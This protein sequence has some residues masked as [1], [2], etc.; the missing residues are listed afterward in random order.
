[1]TWS[2]L[3]EPIKQIIVQMTVEMNQ[4]VRFKR[5]LH[6]IYANLLFRT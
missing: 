3:P 5:F 2:E 1:M 4:I 6:L